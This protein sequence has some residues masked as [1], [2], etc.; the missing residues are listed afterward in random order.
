MYM[1]VHV[2]TY[3]THVHVYIYFAF[4]LQLYI[5]S[6]IYPIIVKCNYVDKYMYMHHMYMYSGIN[7]YKWFDQHPMS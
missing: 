6:I 5:Y 2:C 3:Y 1:Y 4:T 7:Y